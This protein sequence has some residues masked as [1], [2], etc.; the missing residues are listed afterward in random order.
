M[1]QLSLAVIEYQIACS[2]L[3]FKPFKKGKL[4]LQTS[5]KWRSK[6]WFCIM[7]FP[8]DICSHASRLVVVVV[9]NVIVVVALAPN[10]S[11]LLYFVSSEKCMA[12][13]FQPASIRHRQLQSIYIFFIFL[14][15][16]NFVDVLIEW[17]SS[18][19][20]AYASTFCRSRISQPARSWATSSASSTFH[21]PFPP[22]TTKWRPWLRLWRAWAGL[23]SRLSTRKATMALR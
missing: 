19:I 23:M 10:P 1:Q 7:Q 14:L 20:F 17:F 13:H 3:L 8:K 11:T 21:A 2:C 16:R 15:F 22:T 9:V 4:K 12:H 6:L 18:N 5:K